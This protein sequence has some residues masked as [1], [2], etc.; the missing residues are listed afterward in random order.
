MGDRL[1]V[2]IV[3]G[4]ISGLTLAHCLDLNPNVEYVV[5]EGREEVHP[6]VGASIVILPNGSRIFDQLGFLD[7]VLEVQESLHQ[8]LTWNEKGD[9]LASSDAPALIKKR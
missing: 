8:T 5:L 9:L 3:G 1:R 7:D 6:E 4:S 2:I